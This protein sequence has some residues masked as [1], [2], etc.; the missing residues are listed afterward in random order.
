MQTPILIMLSGLPGCGKST[1]SRAIKAAFPHITFIVVGNDHVRKELFPEPTYSAEE[2]ILTYRAVQERIITQ[3]QIGHSVIFDATN[4]WVA[5]RRWRHE[6]V[7]LTGCRMLLLEV[8][9]DRATAHQRITQ[10]TAIGKDISDA[11][12]KTYELMRAQAEPITSP[13]YVVHTDERFEADMR[14]VVAEIGRL[15]HLTT[16]IQ[17]IQKAIAYI[18]H[19]SQILLFL[20]PHAPEAGIQVPAGTVKAEESWEAA[21]LRE[22]AEETGLIGLEIVQ[23]L[24]EA[25]RDMSDYGKNE[26]QQRHFFQLTA[27]TNQPARWQQ[28]EQ[29]GEDGAQHLFELFWVEQ[30]AMPMLIADQGVLLDHVR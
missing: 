6:A 20:H 9:L 11:G 30:S 16:P 24:G 14:D 2:T 21:V 13:H 19:G 26:L 8:V 18:T 28:L 10:R 15:Q 3:L 12:I 1:V 23:Y 7:R 27:P 22:A 5:A 4:I 29:F 25:W 17:T